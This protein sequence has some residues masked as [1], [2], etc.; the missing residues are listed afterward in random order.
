MQMADVSAL[1]IESHSSDEPKP[2]PHS[3]T[4]QHRKNERSGT[5]QCCYSCFH[6]KACKICA[7]CCCCI[8]ITFIVLVCLAVFGIA[9]PLLRDI[10]YELCGINVTETSRSYI[11]MTINAAVLN[12]TIAGGAIPYVDLSIVTGEREAK[13]IPMHDSVTRSVAYGALVACQMRNE[14]LDA[15]Q[16]NDLQVHCALSQYRS[17]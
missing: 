12:P 15:G 5:A 6:S 10:K 7:G 11:A 3:S 17:A 9:L 13:Y 1:E 2:Y 8:M 16:P 14:T 4:T